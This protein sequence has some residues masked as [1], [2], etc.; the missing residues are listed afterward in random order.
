MGKLNFYNPGTRDIRPELF[1]DFAESIAKTFASVK[2]SEDF[3]THKIK[4]FRNGVTSTQLRKL[5]DE[6]KRYQRIIKEGDEKSWKENFPYIK[7]IKAKTHYTIARAKKNDGKNAEYY[8]KVL[9]FISDGIDAIENY[10][11]YSVFTALFES[12][13][14]YYYENRPDNNK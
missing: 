2:E 6:V 12:V 9:S 1:N 13:Y 8:D 7:M 4:T 14:G 10:Q 5:F 11:D 3:K